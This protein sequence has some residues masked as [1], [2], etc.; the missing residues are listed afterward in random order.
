MTAA[1]VMEAKNDVIERRKEIDATKVRTPFLT[2]LVLSH[3][4][5]S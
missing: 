4:V 2:S 3:P 1:S 5:L